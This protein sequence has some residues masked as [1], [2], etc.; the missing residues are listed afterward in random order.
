MKAQNIKS[1]TEK[2]SW[3]T[4]PGL[5]DSRGGKRGLEALGEFQTIAEMY[6]GGISAEQDLGA[7]SGENGV[8]QE[9]P[10]F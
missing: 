10:R 9:G 7:A 2:L 3:G 6:N 4:E 1:R 8:I 5:M